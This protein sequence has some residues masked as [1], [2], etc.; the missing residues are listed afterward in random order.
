M[1]HNLKFIDR[2]CRNYKFNKIIKSNLILTERYT[3]L[4]ELLNCPPKSDVYVAG[5]DQ[6]WNKNIT[7]NK[8]DLA[9]FLDFGTEKIRKYSYAASGDFSEEDFLQIKEHILNFKKISVR[10][11]KLKN[12]MTEKGINVSKVLDPT[13]LFND[14]FYNKYESKINVPNQY[15]LFY[16][17]KTK[18]NNE[19]VKIAEKL[20]KEYKLVICDISPIKWKFKEKVI[21]KKFVGPSEF[22]SYIH[23]ASYVVTNSF[24]GTAF[25]IIYK[26]NFMVN[27]PSLKNDRITDL[28]HSLDIENRIVDYNNCDT[29]ESINYNVIEER[30]NDLR[31]ESEFFIKEMVIN[32]D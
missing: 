22:L 9:Y 29:L 25:S 10:E 28:L 14:D 11:N 19:I 7:Q 4:K 2:I 26:K 20:S 30:F 21:V 12:F 18:G 24:H 23:N 17:L 5:S 8:Y 1:I 15:I 32:D 31:L 13:L 3:T 16:G 6:I 27:L